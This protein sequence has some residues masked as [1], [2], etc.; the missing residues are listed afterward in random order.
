MMEQL[1]LNQR[2]QGSSPW[3]STRNDKP[4]L[5]AGFLIYRAQGYDKQ[6]TGLFIWRSTRN[7]KGL[8][9]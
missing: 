9:S 3:R 1:T 7:D 8:R 2:A 4:C 6:S 5:C